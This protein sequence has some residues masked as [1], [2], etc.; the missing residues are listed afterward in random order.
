MSWERWLLPVVAV[1]LANGLAQLVLGGS[2]SD[3]Q[4]LSQ[5]LAGGAVDPS[6]VP[7]LVAGPIAVMIVSFVAS[8]FLYA[9]AIAGLRGT[10]LPLARIVL[11]GLGVVVSSLALMFLLV[12]SI[13]VAMPVLFALGIL[14]VVLL[15][16]MLPMLWYLAL[17]LQFW[18]YALFDGEGIVAAAQRSWDIS[19]GAVLRIFGWSVAVGLISLLVTGIGSV[20]Q[21]ALPGAPAIGALVVGFASSAYSAFQVIVL[22]I[23]YESQRLRATEGPTTAARDWSAPTSAVPPG[24][25]RPGAGP[26]SGPGPDT[27]APRDPDGPPPPPPTA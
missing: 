20:V 12:I 5:A 8:W 22:A 2:L 13:F 15:L 3:T 16:A 9:N 6:Q 27:D 18:A 26:A 1:T 23:L 4:A 10:T 14:G 19:R 11:A 24:W 7:S 21:I 25:G 17:R